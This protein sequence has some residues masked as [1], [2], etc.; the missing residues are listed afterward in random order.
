MR[1]L[2]DERYGSAGGEMAFIGAHSSKWGSGMRLSKW[3]GHE[4]VC[5][6]EE[7]FYADSGEPV[8]GNERECGHCGKANTEE[9]HDGC[10]G[11]LSGVVNA[12]C[13]HGTA[14]EAYIQYDD[15]SELRGERALEVLY[16]MTR[17]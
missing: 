13:G 4:I 6:G 8:A 3:R 17:V 5:R 10:L 15:G 12:C 7:W 2:Q 11:R 1:R 16:I 9:G 14:S